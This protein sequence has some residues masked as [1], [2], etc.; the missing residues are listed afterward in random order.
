MLVVD[1]HEV[2]T[3]GLRV[4]L[5]RHAWVTRCLQATDGE[6]A[7]ALAR[8][9]RPHV[10]L[11]DL[12]LGVESGAEL[13]QRLRDTA[14][15]MQVLLMSSGESV[16]RP[17]IER[18]G[19]SGFV[20]KR[21]KVDEIIAAVR[22]VGLGMRLEMGSANGRTPAR[23][24][25]LTRREEQVI[26]L[27]ATGATNDQIASVLSVSLYTVKQHAHAAYRKLDARNRTDAVQRAQRLGLIA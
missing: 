3:W 25:T 19:A 24:S 8:R 13:C 9:Y 7:L 16:G 22:I 2:V 21:W 23:G 10:A 1:D 18:A 5:T 4:Q 20:S 11:V 26:A 6:S 15:T 27:M 12:A 17:A 14:P